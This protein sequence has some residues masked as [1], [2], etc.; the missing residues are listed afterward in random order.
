VQL[1]YVPGPKNV[2]PR[3][4]LT[5]PGHPQPTA[6]LGTADAGVVLTAQNHDL[7]WGTDGYLALHNSAGTAIW[8]SSNST[9]GSEFCFQG[10]GN[11]VLYGPSGPVWSSDT[12]DGEHGG[13]GGL[14]MRLDS[15]CNLIVVNASQDVLF[16]TNTTCVVDRAQ[17]TTPSHPQPTDCLGTADAGTIL[18]SRF[19]DLVWE[20]DGYLVLY[21]PT[22][23][24]IWRSPNSTPGSELC[25][26]SDGNFVIYGPSFAVWASNTA[27]AQHGG[28]G[29]FSMLINQSCQLVILNASGGTLFNT[30]TSCTSPPLS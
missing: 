25:F 4:Q 1:A 8:R 6:C 2:V 16:Q 9:P 14:W 13:N 19:H 28:N 22:H 29:G 23:A 15:S 7:I 21:D 27:D 10:D 30:D 24:P 5:T 3:V 18:T 26:Q 17:L 12:A 20:A 11:L